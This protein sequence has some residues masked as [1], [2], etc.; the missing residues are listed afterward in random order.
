MIGW[1]DIPES[2][3]QISS[4]GQV[5]R[6]LSNGYRD[7]K[8]FSTRG[9]LAVNLRINGKLKKVKVHKLMALAF[10]IILNPDEI[11]YFINGIKSDCQLSNIGVINKSKFCK[12]NGFKT[13]SQQVAKIDKFGD[14]VEVYKSA[15]EC[16]R[17]NFMNYRTVSNRCN[18]KIKDIYGLDGFKYI[19]DKDINY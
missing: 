3:Y 18:G 4:L 5:R 16:G 8:S 7:L 9:Y 15:R 6:V 19:W 11:L 2:R 10:N 1:V 12:L 14:I 17:M 13:L